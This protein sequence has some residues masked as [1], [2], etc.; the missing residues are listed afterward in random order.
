VLFRKGD[1]L[2]KTRQAKD[3]YLTTVLE[4]ESP[5]GFFAWNFFDGILMQKEGY[6][7]YVFEDLAAAYLKE[8]PELRQALEDKKSRDPAFAA[9]AGAQLE[10]VYKHSPWYEPNHMIY[11]VARIE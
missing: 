4:P 2:I 10:W 11:P 5:D 3:L 8:H 1:Y 9:S 7:D 6:S